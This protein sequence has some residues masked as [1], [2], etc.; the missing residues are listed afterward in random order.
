MIVPNIHEGHICRCDYQ[1]TFWNLHGSRQ[2]LCNPK[3]E[4]VRCLSSLE[5]ISHMK[6]SSLGPGSEVNFD[7]DC[8]HNS[9]WLQLQDVHLNISRLVIAEHN[10]IAITSHRLR[11][12]WPNHIRVIKL[13]KSNLGFILRSQ[14]RS[15][16]HLSH[17]QGLSRTCQWA[18]GMQLDAF[19]S[20]GEPH[21]CWQR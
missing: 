13:K 15:L 1:A 18:P 2:I 10:T 16:E 17:Y 7:L 8:S 19:D 5:S 21:N 12:H 20:I 6:L 11:L 4:G 3:Y 9:L 14:S